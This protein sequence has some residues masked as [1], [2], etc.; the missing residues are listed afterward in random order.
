MVEKVCKNE[1]VAK[2][3]CTIIVVNY[4]LWVAN[5]QSSKPASRSFVVAMILLQSFY[6]SLHFLK[7]LFKWLEICLACY[8]YNKKSNL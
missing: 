2:T 6:K 8:F 7:F 1:K 5:Y 3:F 4:V